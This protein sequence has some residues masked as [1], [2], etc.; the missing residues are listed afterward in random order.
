MPVS[1]LKIGLQGQGRFWDC[2]SANLCMP[3]TYPFQHVLRAAVV[4]SAY[5]MKCLVSFNEMHGKT[6]GAF[7]GVIRMQPGL[8]F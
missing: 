3:V 7:G 6:L 4:S 5:P 8:S 2:A 1:A